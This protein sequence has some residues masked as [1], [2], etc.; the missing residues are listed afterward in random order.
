QPVPLTTL[1]KGETTQRW[2]QMLH[3]GKAVL[4][5]SNGVPDGF[6][7][8]NVVVQTLPNGP[9]TILV[10]GAYYGRV[11]PSGH[12]VYVHDGV[13]FAARF[14]L[15][16]LELTGQAVPALRDVTVNAPVGAAELTFSDTGTVAYLP[17]PEHANYMDAPIDWM[18]RNGKTK[19]LRT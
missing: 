1:D 2:P 7:E 5:T 10:R 16:R 14:D 3:G 13:V 19:A 8:A 9:R 18:D 6:K 15:D 4:F 11:L 12:L 17:A